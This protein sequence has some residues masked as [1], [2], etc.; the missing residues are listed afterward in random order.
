MTVA[1]HAA[2]VWLVDGSTVGD[3]ALAGFMSW[4]TPAEAQRYGRFVRRER[5]RQFLIGR[6][7]LRQA[8]GRL[9]GMPGSSVRLLERAGNAPLLDLPGSA[10]VGFSLSH[11]GVWIACA[12]SAT[13][14]VGLD[15]EVIDPA[16]DLAALAAQAFDSEQNAWLAARPEASRA[17]DF[18]QLWS[19]KEALFKLQLPSAQCIRLMHPAL[20][21]ALCSAYRLERAPE[22][23]RVALLPDPVPDSR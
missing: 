12:V 4:L 18:Y 17:R 13:T 21:V 22:L 16:R 1:T 9:L 11:S 2:Q 20:S 19:E 5:Q 10:S 7:L 8:L 3:R 15:I 23:A 6:V 14:A